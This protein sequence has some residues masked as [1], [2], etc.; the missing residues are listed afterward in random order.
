MKDKDIIKVVQAHIDGKP[1]Q[2]KSESTDSLDTEWKDCAGKL[3]WNFSYMDYRIKQEPRKF[4]LYSDTPDNYSCYEIM[5]LDEEVIDKIK[6]QFTYAI[7]V[8]EDM[9]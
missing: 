3:L 8:T 5:G 2:Y 4:L 7:E 6:R 9:E 1:I